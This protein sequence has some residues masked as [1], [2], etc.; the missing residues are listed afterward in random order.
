MM[1]K[2]AKQ[3]MAG[4]VCVVIA[5]SGCATTAATRIV[6]APLAP[7]GTASRA[8]LVEYVQKLPPGTAVRID[9]AKG[10]SLR[11]TLMKATDRSIFVQPRTRIPE[12]VVEIAMDNVVGVTPV[13]QGG[14]NL[15][16]AI[17]AGAAAGAGATLAIFLILIA[18][19]GD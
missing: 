8:V 4:L 9:R 5:T 17:G 15:G 14:S 3:V 11:G 16:R 18:A 10:R 6:S 1:L 7:H 12:G 13:P 2:A 19:V